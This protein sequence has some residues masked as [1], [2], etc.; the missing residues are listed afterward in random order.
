MAIY[1][2]IWLPESENYHSG[3]CR[4]FAAAAKQN[5][6]TNFRRNIITLCHFRNLMTHLLT[7][8]GISLNSHNSYTL[9]RMYIYFERI[10]YTR[11]PKYIIR[12]GNIIFTHVIAFYISSSVKNW[13]QETLPSYTFAR[14][15]ITEAF[16]LPAEATAT[17]PLLLRVEWP[18]F[19]ILRTMTAVHGIEIQR[20]SNKW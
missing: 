19:F 6:L 10:V 9:S 17:I 1:W 20:E 14:E 15:S 12:I 16:I 18:L 2:L 7:R 4:N 13:L 8:N 5:E 11:T 3:A